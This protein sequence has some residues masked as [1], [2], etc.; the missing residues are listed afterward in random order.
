MPHFTRQ[1]DAN[2]PILNVMVGVSQARSSALLVVGEVVP[3]PVLG[4]GLV[5]TG[6]SCTCIDP[7][8]MLALGITP[9]G[10]ATMATPSTG[11]D[12]VTVDQYDVSLAIYSTTTE[13]S[14]GIPNLPIIESELRTKQGLDLLIGR[15]V[16]S[17]C[18]LHYNGQ[19][20]LYTLAF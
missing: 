19:T 10:K 15:D 12:V 14:Y 13:P 6:A 17:Q 7:D 20:G 1:I 8:L 9:S 2:G 5:D 11:T 4:K 3:S 18:I 16:L